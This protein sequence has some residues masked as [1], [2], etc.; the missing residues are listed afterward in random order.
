MPALMDLP[1]TQIKNTTQIVV[2][3]KM[4]ESQDKHYKI[5]MTFCFYNF[6]AFWPFPSPEME[7]TSSDH[8]AAVDLLFGVDLLD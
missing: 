3:I 7:V 5:R 8:S 1:Q 6:N 2:P 4:H